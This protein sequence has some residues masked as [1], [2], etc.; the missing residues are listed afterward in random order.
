[1][2]SF[3]VKFLANPD[4]PERYAR[5]ATLNKPDPATFYSGGARG[6]TDYPFLERDTLKRLL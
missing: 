6:Y 2:I 4:L 5:W 3:G 1:M